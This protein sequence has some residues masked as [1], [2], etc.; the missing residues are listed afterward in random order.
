MADGPPGRNRGLRALT[1]RWRKTGRVLLERVRVR[2]FLVRDG[3]C[4]ER[5]ERAELGHGPIGIS[6]VADHV[7]KD[8]HTKAA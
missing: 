8:K 2:L 3:R 1:R 4:V 7:V 6:H 5:L